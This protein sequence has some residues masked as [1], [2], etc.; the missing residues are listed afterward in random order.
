MASARS[1]TVILASLLLYCGSS[2]I[3]VV[4]GDH[5][6]S[7]VDSSSSLVPSEDEFELQQVFLAGFRRNLSNYYNI[8]RFGFTADGGTERCIIIQYNI[9]CNDTNEICTDGVLSDKCSLDNNTVTDWTFLWTSFEA[10]YSDVGKTL[11]MLAVYDLRVF[12]FELCDIYQEPVH[13]T[14]SL[15]SSDPRLATKSCS[16]M[17]N[18]FHLFTTLVSIQ[19]SIRLQGSV[20]LSTACL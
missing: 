5:P 3:V 11:L 20:I 15:N 19:Y 18:V 1:S 14:F 13:V 4:K 16:S 9:E 12:G 8:R 17:C 2:V 7:G 6:C 10:Q